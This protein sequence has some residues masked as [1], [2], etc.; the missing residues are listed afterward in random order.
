MS[1]LRMVPLNLIDPPLKPMRIDSLGE[2][3]EELKMDL[4]KRG[5]MQAIG[6]VALDTGRF[7]LVWGS[8]RCAAMEEMGWSDV[9]SKVH[10]VGEID[11]MESMAA[12]NFQRTQLNPVEEGEFYA[13]LIEAKNISVAEC[14]RRVHKSPATVSR[15]LSFLGGDGEVRAALSSGAINQGQA[16]QLN[17]VRDDIGR[18]QG[19]AWAKGGLMTARAL[20]GWREN[21]EVTGISD[22]VEQVQRNLEALPVIDYRTMAKCVLHGQ[23]V[24]LM[25][26]PPRVICDE[27]WELVVEAITY[28]HQMHAASSTAPLTFEE[29]ENAKD[30]G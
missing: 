1:E 27:C 12:E 22:S 15:M 10:Q 30:Q 25:S 21:R 20:A 5:Q 3:L 16:E 24:E 4:E 6:V 7:R 9:M 26:A 28:Y 29:D 14:A 19:L 8:R 11:E 13:N 23:F 18:A 2:G 17:L